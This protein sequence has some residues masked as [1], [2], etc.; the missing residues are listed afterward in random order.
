M[1]TGLKPPCYTDK[2]PGGAVLWQPYSPQGFVFVAHGFSLASVSL[3]RLNPLARLSQLTVGQAGVG[4][5]STRDLGQ[6][7]A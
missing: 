2:A 6:Y 4:G 3:V 5:N 1:L 7:V